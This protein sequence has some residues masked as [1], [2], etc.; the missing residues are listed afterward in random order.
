MM[1]TRDAHVEALTAGLIRPVR[2]PRLPIVLVAT[3]V[4]TAIEW[5]DFFLY[6]TAAALVFPRLFFPRFEPLVGTLLAFATFAVGFVARPVGGVVFGHFGDRIGR[7]AML[8]LT[9]VLMGTATFAIGLLPT[10]EA[11]GVAAPIA[12]VAL[13]LVQGFGLGGEWGGA[14]LMAV[15]HAPAGK[16]GFYGSWPQTGA[17]AGLLL[18][19]AAFALASRL[20]DAAFLSWGWRLPFLASVVLVGVGAVVRASLPESPELARVKDGG[21][22]ARLPIVEVLREHKRGV[23]LAMG[24]RL[25][26]NAFFYVYTTFVLAYATEQVHVPRPTVL[27][28]VLLA[29]GV[30]LVAIPLFGRL[31]DRF[32][33]RPVYLAGAAFSALFVV[34]FFVLVGTG[35]GAL[36][37]LAIVVGV[38]VGHAAMYGPQAALFANLFG[39]RVRYSGASLGYQLASVLAGG[40]SPVVAAALLGWSHGA[41]WPVAAYMTVLALT[42]LGSVWATP[43]SAPTCTPT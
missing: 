24:A 4:G 21:N 9:L 30:D 11:I 12:L 5:Y 42:T 19:T 20:P 43:R 26:E 3:F 37:W 41:W 1:S 14:V 32:G 8:G 13:R 17:P 15:E 28:G 40:L 2:P 29:A 35:R 18:S 6:G 38:A 36:V 23:A 7:K 22:A 34:P 25:A 39:A 10:Y 27:A 16:R 33:G 31:S